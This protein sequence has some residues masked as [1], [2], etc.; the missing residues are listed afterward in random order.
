MVG[1]LISKTDTRYLIA[2]GFAVTSIGL[3]RFSHLTL[4]ISFS[5]AMWTRV[6]QACGLAFLFVPINTVAYAGMPREKSNSISGITNLARNIGGSVGISFVTTFLARRSQYHQN[7]LVSHVD[8]YSDAVRSTIDGTTN[9]LIQHGSAP[10]TAAQQAYGNLYHTLGRQASFLGYVD[11]FWL[12]AVFSA[13]MV[14]CVFLMKR[15]RPAAP[16]AH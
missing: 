1:L 5:D 6:L 3:F 4:D 10:A 9:A 11:T 14:P 2:F 16:A 15:A 13:C 8:K 7:V 12:L